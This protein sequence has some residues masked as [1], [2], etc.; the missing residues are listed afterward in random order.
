[1]ALVTMMV[2][3]LAALIVAGC[4]RYVLTRG[5]DKKM[6]HSEQA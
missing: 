4:A 2:I 3:Q 6:G 1:V 5:N